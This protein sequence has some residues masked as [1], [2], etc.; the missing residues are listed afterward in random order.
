MLYGGKVLNFHSLT[1]YIYIQ[2]KQNFENVIKHQTPCIHTLTPL[3]KQPARH[4]QSTRH[5]KEDLRRPGK[6]TA[7]RRPRN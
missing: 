4:I 5:Q 7:N 6:T 3:S 2:T 1:I